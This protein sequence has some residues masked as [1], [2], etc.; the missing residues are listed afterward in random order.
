RQN[1]KKE[2]PVSMDKDDL[3]RAIDR[4]D[5]E[6]LRLL[7]ERQALAGRLGELKRSLGLPIYDP[8][9]E[10][11]ILAR[12]YASRDSLEERAI[13]SVWREIFSASRQAQNPLR[14]AYLGPE[15]TFTHQAAIVK[16]GT[17]AE[18]IAAHTIAAAFKMVAKRTV[19]Y[20][21]LPVENTLQGVVG[22]TVDLLGAARKALIIGEV[23][24]PIHFVFSSV[25][26]RLNDI[27]TVYSKQE[28]FPQ[29]ANF[30]NQPALGDARRVAVASTSE[31]V[32]R[33]KEDPAGAALST[34]VAAN[35]AGVPILFRN[36]ENNPRNKTRFL[37]L[38]HDRPEPGTDHKTSVFAKVQN[39]AGGLEGLLAAFKRNNI[40]LTKIESRP[41]DD[42]ANFETWFYIEF[43]GHLNDLAV[44][45]IFE[46]HDL[47]WLGS[48]PKGNAIEDVPWN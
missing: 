15:G 1:P 22:E 35:Q 3:R 17:S 12:Q 2:V 46:K 38:G 32:W 25:C 40:N 43:E 34:E 4:V 9:R 29:C 36:V 31:A 39:V 37:V 33:A 45:S 30:L 48:Y 16:F 13:T 8:R 41:M 11:E 7:K 6:L 28:A 14:A 10:E 26:D 24:L 44:R 42:A 23:T 18:L 5:D 20:A 21:V 19:D 27:R 47:V